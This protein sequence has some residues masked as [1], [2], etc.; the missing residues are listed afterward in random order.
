MVTHL[1]RRASGIAWGQAD[2]QTLVPCNGV[3]D[4][5]TPVIG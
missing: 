5:G 1:C 3:T 4:I 2:E